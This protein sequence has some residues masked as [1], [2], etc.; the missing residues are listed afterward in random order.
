[1]LTRPVV[2][3]WLDRVIGTTLVGLGIRLAVVRTD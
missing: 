1:V 3:R 2:K